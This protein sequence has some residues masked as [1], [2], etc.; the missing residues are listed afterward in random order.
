MT[1]PSERLVEEHKLIKRMLSV[2]SKAADKLESGNEVDPEIFLQAVDFIR[3]FADRFHHAKEE[4]ILFKLM[5]D[6]GF[7][8]DGGP[9][10][11]MLI[12]HDQGRNF[13]KGIEDGVKRWQAGEDSAK[14]DVINNARNYA[15]LLTN[16]IHKEDH[17]LYPM[18]DKAF[19]DADHQFLAKEYDR[20]E[21]ESSNI[22]V[23]QKYVVMV[24]QLET[25]F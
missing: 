17:I 14:P 24:E 7:P 12:E 4:D 1:I 9:V 8:V 23:F 18:G 25:Q 15:Q 2:V 5:G 21:K 3:N 6:R 19:T 11:V 22:G 16:H 13:T 20:V 10:G